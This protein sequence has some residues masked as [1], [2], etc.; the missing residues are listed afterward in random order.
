[1]SNQHLHSYPSRL[2]E[3]GHIA[4]RHLITTQFEERE[5]LLKATGAVLKCFG[6]QDAK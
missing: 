6:S 4:R 2:V 3:W 1:M 5:T